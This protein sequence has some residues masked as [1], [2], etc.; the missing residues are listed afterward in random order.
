MLWEAG[1]VNA[2]FSGAE[3]VHT[4]KLRVLKL[5]GNEVDLVALNIN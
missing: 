2:G 1:L 3:G 4:V 5:E